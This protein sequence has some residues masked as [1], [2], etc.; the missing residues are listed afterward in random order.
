MGATSDMPDHAARTILHGSC[1]ALG[2]DRAV[3]ITGASGSGKS[4]LALQLMAL[5]A[6]LVADDK[7][8]V[9]LRGGALV[10]SAPDTIAGL[11]EARGVGILRADPVPEA[12]LVLAVDMDREEKDRLPHPREIH[13]LGCPVPLLCCVQAPHFAPALLQMLR[14]G[15]HA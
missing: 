11:I 3:V 1:V 14:E 12:R 10:A 15:R 7:T 8:C 9:T 2:E 4:A 5:G 13:L 6:R